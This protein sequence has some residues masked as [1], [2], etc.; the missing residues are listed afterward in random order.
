[1]VRTVV[2]S[3]PVVAFIANAAAIRDRI[4]L[5]VGVDL[6]VGPAEPS[7]FGPGEEQ[8]TVDGRPIVVRTRFGPTPAGEAL[9]AVNSAERRG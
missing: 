2:L 8:A 6:V 7:G 4:T 5:P 9:F 3:A 1:M